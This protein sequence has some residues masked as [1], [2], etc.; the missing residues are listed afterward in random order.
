MRYWR[1]RFDDNDLAG[2]TGW[3]EFNDI[4][5]TNRLLDDGG[6]PVTEGISYSTIDTDPAPPS[7]S[8]P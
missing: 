4:D 2:Q 8:A 6:T 1:I 7:W 3:L 5:G